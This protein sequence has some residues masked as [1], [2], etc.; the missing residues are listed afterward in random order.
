MFILGL[1]PFIFRQGSGRVP[2]GLRLFST[3]QGARPVRRGT[4]GADVKGRKDVPPVSDSHPHRTSFPRS[5]TLTQGGP[6]VHES[7]RSDW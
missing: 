2:D 3:L 1:V 6:S 5:P 7:L 4:S